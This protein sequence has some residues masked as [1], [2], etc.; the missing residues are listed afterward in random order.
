MRIDCH[1]GV[2]AGKG[3]RRMR[4]QIV[5]L[6]VLLITV[7][8]LVV[9]TSVAGTSVAGTAR[10]AMPAPAGERQAAS[11]PN[12]AAVLAGMETAV[13]RHP[14]DVTA[15]L[16][17]ADAYFNLGM[18]EKAT[19]PDQAAQHFAQAA[20]AYQE[21]ANRRDTVQVAVN[22]ALAAFY[23]KNYELA[24]RVF[25]SACAEYAGSFEVH[26]NYGVFLYHAKQDYPAAI[27]EWHTALEIKPTGPEADQLQKLI[28]GLQ[29]M[30]Q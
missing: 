3:Y 4:K 9:A 24:G 1:P 11:G 30:T 16:Q 2:L 28:A 22:L 13:S 10:P 18:A 29:G 7:L 8:V 25:Q 21:A 19:T 17:L 5:F 20:A 15:R 26:Y 27:K 12:T 6:T 14:E 23:A